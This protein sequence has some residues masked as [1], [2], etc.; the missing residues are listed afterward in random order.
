MKRRAYH[1]SKL[2]REQQSGSAGGTRAAAAFAKRT[3]SPQREWQ[4][5]FAFPAS[6]VPSVHLVGEHMGLISHVNATEAVHA[7][8]GFSEHVA[9]LGEFDRQSVHGSPHVPQVTVDDLH[10]LGHA[11]VVIAAQPP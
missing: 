10:N 3:C 1:A 2:M 8:V 7:G 6:F 4:P 11:A 9:H 5:R